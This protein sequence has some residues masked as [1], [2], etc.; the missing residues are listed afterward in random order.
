MPDSI[1][2]I[3]DL[4][5]T[6]KKSTGPAL[7][8]GINLSIERGSICALVGDSGSGKSLI[9][10]SV[11][12]ILADNLNCSGEILFDDENL[13]GLTEKRLRTIRGKQIGVVMQ[14]CAGSLDPLLKNGRHLS[15]AVRAHCLP[16]E[17][18]RGRCLA[19]LRGVRLSEPEQV[20]RQYPHQLSG[21]MKQRLLTAISLAGRPEFLIMD[22][23]TKGLDL[24]LRDQTR[25]MIDTVR[26]EAGITI[27]LITHDLEL[28][29]ALSDDCYV[30]RRGEITAHGPTKTL[31]RE[32]QDETL[33]GLL[34]AE[35]QMNGFFT[36]SLLG[37]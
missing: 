18:V 32:A 5:V 6:M 33:A 28:A 4:R 1:L 3:R 2:D 21:G 29:E 16:G 30:I 7:V 26:R 37:R 15:M 17:D 11:M 19:L 34:L 23:P 27:L 36:D 22:E 25:E 10:S 35:H 9:A 24:T 20:M 14:N 31:F 8:N 12:G 13:L